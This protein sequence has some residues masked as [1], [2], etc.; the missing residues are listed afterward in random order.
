M[1]LAQSYVF[2]NNTLHFLFA[3]SILMEVM[4]EMTIFDVR[5]LRKR[6]N[7]FVNRVFYMI[8]ALHQIWMPV[9]IWGLESPC[10]KLNDMY[11]STILWI[12][13]LDCQ[14]LWR[15][16]ER[17]Q[18]LI[19]NNSLKEKALIVG[20]WLVAEKSGEAS[21]ARRTRVPFET[22]ATQKG[23]WPKN[24]VPWSGDFGVS[25]AFEAFVCLIL[26]LSFHFLCIQDHGYFSKSWVSWE[27][28]MF[29]E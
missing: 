1:S 16:Y 27:L 23:W 17:W 8:K 14:H 29:C 6:R 7:W 12:V 13:F 11:S 10:H 9:M 18:S 28:D 4:W 15:W 20:K 2:I 26:S 3:L 19:Y 25:T 5:I 22:L 24:S 21:V